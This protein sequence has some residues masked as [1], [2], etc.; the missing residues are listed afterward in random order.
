MNRPNV[1]GAVPDGAIRKV[2]YDAIVPG[3]VTGRLRSMSET[4]GLVLPDIRHPAADHGSNHLTEKQH[5]PT[6]QIASQARVRLMRLKVGVQSKAETTIAV[7]ALTIP[8]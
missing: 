2:R 3:E 8:K 6:R 7:A 1:E 4:C 5:H